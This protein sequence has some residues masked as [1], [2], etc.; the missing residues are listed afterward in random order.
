M[1]WSKAKTILIIAFLITN[2][3]LII[4]LFSSE[5]HIET[6]TEEEFVQDVIRLLNKK[7]IFVDTEIPKDIP[8]LNTVTVEYEIINTNEINMKFFNGEGKI[9]ADGLDIVDIFYEEEHIIITN[10]KRLLYKN[11]NEINKYPEL[12]EDKAK[13]IAL[14]FL[15][16]KEYNTS[17]T[18]LS[19]ISERDNVYFL[20]F[21]NLYNEKYLE[22]SNII[23]EIDYRGV[24]SLERIWLNT[25]EE[26][27]IPIYI[28]TAPKAILSLLS[29]EE[30]YGKT[31][32]DISLCYYFD[33]ESHEYIKDPKEAKRGKTIPAWRVLFDDGYKVIIDN[34]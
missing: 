22:T 19:Y 30:V 8:S 10:Q 2:I 1:D 4:V 3:L 13:T 33:P 6:T 17:N 21:S 32:K 14:E 15:E 23:M 20:E 31:V 25:L 5:K 16:D 34:Y 11:N 28:N 29:R 12:N 18:Q 7:S 9:T 27:E 24:R 26:G